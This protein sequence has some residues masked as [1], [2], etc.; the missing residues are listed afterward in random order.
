MTG[1]DIPDHG[2]KVVELGEGAVNLRH[3]GTNTLADVKVFYRGHAVAAVAADSVDIAEEAIRKIVVDY[4]VL[5]HVT[6]VQKAMEPGL[7]CC[8]RICSLRKLGP[9]SRTRRAMSAAVSTS[10]K[11]TQTR[12]FKTADVVVET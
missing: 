10:S 11:A 2:N 7:Q 8:T 9:R 5:P 1:A 4:E 3:L 6:D 12:A